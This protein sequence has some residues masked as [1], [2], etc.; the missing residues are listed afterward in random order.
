V[1]PAALVLG[2]SGGIGLAS[3]AMLADEGYDLTI[4]GRRPERVEAALEALDGS[5]EGI[6]ADLGKESE[7]ARAVAAHAERWGR[8]DVLVDSAGLGIGQGVGE[9]ETR[10]LDLQIAVN[11]RAAVL[12]VRESLPLLEAAGAAHG[13][14]LVALVSSWAG[15]HPPTW[16]SI[17]G[18]TKAALNSFARSAQAELAD[19]GVQVTALS[20]ATVETELTRYAQGAIPPEQMLRPTDVAESLRMLLRLSPACRV[21]EVLLG[22]AGDFDG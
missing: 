10:H 5:A 16:L 15:A 20:P 14:A 17:Y 12:A 13:K 2:G 22:R 8:M 4:Q 7:I 19:K 1:P 11:F 21:P 3:A 18:A 6:A 9:I